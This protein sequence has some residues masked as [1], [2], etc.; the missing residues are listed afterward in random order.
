MLRLEICESFLYEFLHSINHWSAK[1]VFVGINSDPFNTPA[2][3]IAC[4]DV[5]TALHLNQS[6]KSQ[7][8]ITGHFLG[9]FLRASTIF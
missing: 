7:T 5:G 3:T 2:V 8:V 9:L 1:I 6:V 4:D